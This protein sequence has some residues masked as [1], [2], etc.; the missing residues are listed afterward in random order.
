MSKVTNL[1][2][3]PEYEKETLNLI[4]SA[5]G[6]DKKNSFSVDFYPLFNKD[7]FKNCHILLE[8]KK[9]IGHIGCLPRKLE[10]LTLHPINMYGG[11]A[12]HPDYRGKGFFTDFFK[13]VLMSSPKAALHFLWSEQLELYERFDFYPCLELNHYN[14]ADSPSPSEWTKTQLNKLEE[15]QLRQIKDL[16]TTN[17]E[18]RIVR[19]EKHW[20]SLSKVTSSELYLKLDGEKILNYF[21]MHKGQDLADIIHEYGAIDNQVLSEMIQYGHVWSPFNA[22]ADLT[23]QILFGSVARLGENQLLNT[24]LMEYA[25]TELIETRE[26]ELTVKIDD[27]EFTLQKKDFLPGLLGPGKFKEF[28]TQNIFISGLDSI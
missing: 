13:Q 15:S 6:Y 23:K 14:R 12:M 4:E 17:D 24:L 7:N 26:E 5:L 2:D 27:E 3:S 20:G 9:V 16:Y 8:D 22:K 18:I 11:I 25:G 19:D 1:Y 28:E 21:F 10:L